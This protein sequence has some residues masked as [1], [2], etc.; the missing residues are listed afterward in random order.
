MLLYRLAQRTQLQWV[1]VGRGGLVAL[2]LEL[3]GFKEV[4]LSLLVLQQRLVVALELTGRVHLAVG[5]VAA[6]EMAQLVAV[7]ELLGKVIQ[8]ALEQGLVITGQA[9][10]AVLVQ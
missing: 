10:G 6:G 9:V 1:L 3:L 7:Q 4:T 2:E 5:R 8:V